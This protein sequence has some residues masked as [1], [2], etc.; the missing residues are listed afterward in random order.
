MGLNFANS[1]TADY[2]SHGSAASLDDLLTFT[3]ILWIYPTAWPATGE[4]RRIISKSDTST[5]NGR[6]LRMLQAQGDGSFDIRINRATTPATATAVSGTMT[7]NAWNYIVISY[8]ESA[9]PLLY[10]GT[11]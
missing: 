5:G 9:G 10:F 8:D 2:V 7:L 11:L 3:W 6:D 1:S 4:V